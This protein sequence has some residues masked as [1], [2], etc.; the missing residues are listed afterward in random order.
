MQQVTAL[1]KAYQSDVR[2]ECLKVILL[3]TGNWANGVSKSMGSSACLNLINAIMNNVLS[4]LGV[5]SLEW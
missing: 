1:I 2:L 4:V 3:E 5:A